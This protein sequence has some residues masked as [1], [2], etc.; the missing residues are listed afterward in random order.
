VADPTVG[1]AVSL[2]KPSSW[3]GRA[4][5]AVVLAPPAFVRLHYGRVAARLVSSRPLPDSA[6]PAT[7]TTTAR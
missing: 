6:A 1:W 4:A 5:P 3:A 2:I 7:K